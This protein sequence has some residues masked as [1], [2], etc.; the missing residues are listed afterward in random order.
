MWIQYLPVSLNKGKQAERAEWSPTGKPVAPLS[1]AD[2]LRERRDLVARHP[3]HNR[4]GRLSRALFALSKP[5]F[6]QSKAHSR[7][8]ENSPFGLRQLKLPVASYREC[9]RFCG[10][11]PLSCASPRLIGKNRFIERSKKPGPF[12]GS[13]VSHFQGVIEG[14]RKRRKANDSLPC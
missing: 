1:F 12:S 4:S 14:L 11:K 13:K 10:S 9:A 2:S 8:F 3:D 5:V 7:G 6:D